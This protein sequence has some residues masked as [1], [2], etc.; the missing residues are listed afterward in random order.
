MFDAVPHASKDFGIDVGG[1]G[2]VLQDIGPAVV[3]TEGPDVAA[4]EE[5][6]AIV[7]FEELADFSPSRMKYVIWFWDSRTASRCQKVEGS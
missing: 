4:G 5:I 3:G 7:L 6:V 1:E 2:V